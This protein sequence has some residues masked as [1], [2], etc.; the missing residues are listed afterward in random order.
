METSLEWK[1]VVCQTRFNSGH[2]MIGGEEK[3]RNNHGKTK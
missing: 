2:R 3:D 1:T